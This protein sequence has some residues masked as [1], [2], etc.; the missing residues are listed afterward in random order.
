MAPPVAPRSVRAGR[1][2]GGE[3]SI[4]RR[5]TVMVYVAADIDLQARAQADLAEMKAAGSTPHLAIVA[6]LEAARIGEPPRRFYLTRDR[7]LAADAIDPAL[8]ETNTG[9]ARDLARFVAWAMEAYPAGRYALMVWNHG[10]GW[11]EVRPEGAVGQEARAPRPR[12][13]LFRVTAESALARGMAWDATSRD[14]LDNTELERALDSALLLSGLDRLDL[15]CLDACLMQMLEVA[16]QLRG[17]ARYVVGSQEGEPEGGWPYRTILRRL[18]AWPEADGA[19]VGAMM[20]DAYVRAAAP[21]EAVTL[22]ALD[23]AAIDGVVGA[24]NALCRCVLDNV[25]LARPFVLGAARAAQRYGNADCCDLYDFCRLIWDHTAEIPLRARAR[26]LMALLAPAGPDR[27]VVAEGHRG[28]GVAR[29]HG[30]S[31]Y[32]PVGAFSA[33]YR[34][35]DL[36]SDSLWDEMMHAVRGERTSWQ[37][38]PSPRLRGEG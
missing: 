31:I 12:R 18:A 14:L 21:A 15:L 9:D 16:Y 19:Q 11:S 2:A 30:V 6:Q 25:V 23:L 32:L 29:S 24:L 5:W 7:P 10:L 22:S 38:V 35:L 37:G 1:L 17:V 28:E 33:F 4:G 3:G 26:E 13:P 34:R 36:A 27:F 20:V 8:G